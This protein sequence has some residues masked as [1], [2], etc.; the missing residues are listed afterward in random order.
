MRCLIAS[1]QG[2]ELEHIVDWLPGVPPHSPMIHI[3]SDRHIFLT[4]GGG[5]ERFLRDSSWEFKEYGVAFV[6]V[7]NRLLICKSPQAKVIGH[8]WFVA[9][10]YIVFHII[11]L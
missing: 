6:L 8:L 5:C 2:V 3:S 4:E 10:S 1:H 7:H 9:A 11:P